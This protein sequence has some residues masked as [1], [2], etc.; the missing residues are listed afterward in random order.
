MK[1]FIKQSI[2]FCLLS[3][4]I[5]QPAAY[6]SIRPVK[7]GITK[8]NLRDF[9]SYRISDTLDI[10]SIVALNLYAVPEFNI[11]FLNDQNG[12]FIQ[13]NTIKEGSGYDFI[14]SGDYSVYD[15]DIFIEAGLRDMK[16]GVYYSIE[17][18]TI[19]LD[20]PNKQF[21]YLAARIKEKIF[22]VSV[23]GK[24]N[25]KSL[26]II[27]RTEKSNKTDYNARYLTAK[28]TELLAS[29]ERFNIIPY[30]QARSFYFSDY[31]EAALLDSLKADALIMLS[32][33]NMSKDME[34]TAT[35]Q[36][37]E[38]KN[39]VSVPAI[40]QS[41]YEDLRFENVVIY[42]MKN[43]LLNITDENGM[44]I[45]GPFETDSGDLTDLVSKGNYNYQSE[46]YFVSNY[47]LY[48]AMELKPDSCDLHYLA[49]V[50]YQY[51]GYDDGA[52]IEFKKTIA[53]DPGSIDAYYS[54]GDVYYGQA[55]DSFGVIQ[56]EKVY[57][58]DPGYEYINSDLG[59][60]YYSTKNYQKAIEQYKLALKKDD[61]D[62][63]TYLFLGF[64]YYNLEN[65]DSALYYFKKAKQINT[66]NKNYSYYIA[67]TLNDQGVK[68]FKDAN[69]EDALNKFR[70]SKNEYPL[71]VIDDNIRIDYIMSGHLDSAAICLNRI[72]EKD[73]AR[74]SNIYYQHAS[75]IRTA[76]LNSNSRFYLS[77]A[78]GYEIIKYA[79]K[80]IEIKPGDEFGYWIIG[81]TYPYLNKTDS[82]F[83]YLEKAYMINKDNSFILLDYTESLCLNKNY[84]KVIHFINEYKDINKAWNTSGTYENTLLRFIL[85]SAE[86]AINNN[87]PEIESKQIEIDFKNG[88]KIKNWDYSVYRKWLESINTNPGYDDL[89][90]LLQL[91]EK[92][93]VR[94]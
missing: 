52:I 68:Y 53:C 19:K 54:L 35:F 46:H 72:L 18:V 28:L 88:I 89:M 73:S 4:F 29:T 51:S 78:F 37:R 26:A 69:Y 17:P 77:P 8:F 15:N 50:N 79:K 56:Y 60:A 59:D 84:E 13:Q 47:F 6:A 57:N 83:V 93:T 2:F 1:N 91:M 7:I 44:I 74:K 65:L 45:P 30:K 75:N 12:Q 14:V 94:E 71:E 86:T 62:D 25:L 24:K 43:L 31:T 70:E 32:F 9:R 63:S 33:K 92:N 5:L 36:S 20:D 34:L 90:K 40:E 76:F 87:F 27:C 64:S 49:G 48:K 67:Y 16:S 55:K 10:R 80:H 3:I 39:A 58:L 11:S 81:N 41:Y 42:W 23:E 22:S 66:W 82:S 38:M 21:S 85:I 61:S